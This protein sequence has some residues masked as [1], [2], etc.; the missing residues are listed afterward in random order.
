MST[1]DNIDKMRAVYAAYGE[2]NAEP[3]CE[4]FAPDGELRHIVPQDVYTF[5]KPHRGPDGARAVIALIVEDYEWLT[6]RSLET[7]AEGETVFSITGGRIRHR[8]SGNEAVLHLADFVR[9]RDGRIREYVQFFD[10]AGAQDWQAG[11]GPPA[12]A[13]MNMANKAI[14]IT[15][16]ETERNR[17]ALTEAYASYREH[18]VNPLLNLFA[19][20]ASYNSVASARDFRF[21]GPNQGRTAV[22]ESLGRIAVDY[23][24][25]KYD[26]LEMVAQD[27]LVA[28]HADAAFR[29]R[30]TGK[31][32]RTEKADIFRMQGGKILEFNEFFD[33]LTARAASEPD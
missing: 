12:C 32:A 22:V 10:S 3:L 24:L 15:A 9:F 33:T 4:A 19:D 29:H 28:V 6:F 20:D 5:A 11:L 31:V 13:H 14:N 2:G 30:K 8:A 17:R 27:D 16:L 23:S 21:A 18:D 7:I 26:V 1:Q 25:V